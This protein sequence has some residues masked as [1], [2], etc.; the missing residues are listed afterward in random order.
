[1][2]HMD[3]DD[4]NNKSNSNETA[5]DAIKI[6][7]EEGGGGEAKRSDMVMFDEPT[8]LRR[9]SQGGM[10]DLKSGE[11]LPNLPDCL[12]Y[13]TCLHDTK[14]PAKATGSEP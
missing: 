9:E 1:M 7:T 2:Q 3:D 6:S 4:S 11:T 10:T 14:N 12:R 5:Q 8:T 13:P